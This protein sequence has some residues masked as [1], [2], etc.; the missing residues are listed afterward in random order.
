MIR[1]P[2]AFI[3]LALAALSAFCA[4]PAFALTHIVRPGDTLA[5][6]AERY[7]G[8]IQLE[9]VLVAANRLDLGGGTA[10]IP[11]LRLEVPTTSSYIVRKGER[12]E[13]LATRFLGSAKRADVLSIANNSSPWMTPAEGLRVLIPYNLAVLVHGDETVMSLAQKYLGDPK[14]AWTLTHYN[15]L[16]DSKLER[17]AVVL[18]PL[19]ELE[20]TDAAQQAAA[21]EG[22]PIDPNVVG[23]K[24]Q[25]KLSAELPTLVAD[26]RGGRYA[27]AVARGHRLLA[28]G[29]LTLPDT[30]LVHRLLLEAYVA[31]DA[32]GAASAACADWRR[33][34]PAARLDPVRLSPKLM[35][36]CQRAK[37]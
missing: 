14:K 4:R 7:Y 18:I 31:L 26:V 12:W 5:A 9:R 37:P 13:A 3:T 15:E 24:Q 2:P 33:A 1:R 22:I 8:R 36:A 23:R 21:L 16:K 29:V 34:D 32:S 25:R 20:L 17:A 27:D 30:A 28:S 35:A 6:L 19:T 10:L 11:G